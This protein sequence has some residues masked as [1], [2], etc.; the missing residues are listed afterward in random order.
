MIEKDAL[1]LIKQ[2]VN[3]WKQN[4]LESITSCLTQNCIV[5]ESHGPTY[6]GISR[7]KEWFKLWLAANSSILKWDVISFN[8]CEKERTAFF[9][10]NF[11]CISNSV[12]YSILG[13]SYVKFFDHRI[14]FIHEYRMTRP[15]YEWKGNELRS[16]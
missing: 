4:N 14:S 12:K 13:I 8:F 16:E 11:V 3:G 2:Y 6:Q 5:I 10:W 1:E 7:I 9:E 15:A